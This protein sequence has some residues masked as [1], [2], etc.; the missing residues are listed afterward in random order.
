M[1]RLPALVCLAAAMRLGY[2]DGPELALPIACSPGTDCWVVNYV[3]I[4]PAKG[5]VSDFQCGRRSYDQHKGTDFAIRDW[6]TMEA[7]VNVIAAAAG[8]VIRVRDGETDRQRTRVELEQIQKAGRECGNGVLI[9]HG[10]GWQTL[11]CHMKQ[12]SISVQ[13]GEKVDA[14]RK[15]GEVGH[16]GFVE[17]PHVHISVLHKKKPIDP[18]TGLGPGAGCGG[19]SQPLWR[20]EIDLHYQPVSI[21]AAGFADSVPEFDAIKLDASGSARIASDATAITFWVALFG[22]AREDQIH[23]EIRGPD[24]RV[25]AARDIAQE[26]DRARQFYFVGRRL[27][28]GELRAGTYTGTAELSRVAAQGV[29]VKRKIQKELKIEPA[30]ATGGEFTDPAREPALSG[31]VPA[32]FQARGRIPRTSSSDSRAR[33]S[34]SS[35]MRSVLSTSSGASGAS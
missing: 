21:Y 34:S 33:T 29:P 26:A 24:G 13:A 18:F 19:T 25:V 30:S 27:K 6:R 23:M 14:G 7:G 2:A 17:F 15:L 20:K 28:G 9:G 5:S 4:D 1:K 10:D 3:D 12:G 11:Y 35:D 31:S 16:S 32:R 22:V 8:S